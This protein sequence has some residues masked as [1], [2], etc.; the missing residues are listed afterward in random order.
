MTFQVRVTGADQL[1]ALADRLRRAG[2]KDLQQEL[3][4]ALVNVAKPLS[5]APIEQAD[6]F[7]PS[8]YAEVIRATLKSKVSVRT[9]GGGATVRL[10]GE[11]M[12]KTSPRKID[13]VEGGELT[14]PLWGNRKYWYTTRVKSGFYTE[15]MLDHVQDIRD[16]IEKALDDVARK[17]EG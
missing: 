2:R 9:V 15:P 14:H 17:I 3:R 10:V 7:L 16:A 4:R 5:Q 8:K 6:N 13:Q 12:G 11:A 1:S